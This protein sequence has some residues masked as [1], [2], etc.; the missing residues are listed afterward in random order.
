M[1]AQGGAGAGP[2]P[3]LP[4]RGAA[5]DHPLRGLRHRREHRVRVG[6][7]QLRHGR[8]RGEALRL[9]WQP[10]RQPLP[11]RGRLLVVCDARSDGSAGSGKT[12]S[13]SWQ[14]RPDCRSRCATSRPHVQVEQDRAPAVLPHHPHLAGSAADDGKTPWPV[15][16]TTTYQGLKAPPSSTR[17]YPGKIKISDQQMKY[18]EERI[19]ARRRPR[20]MELRGPARSPPRPD[21][22]PDPTRGQTR[23]SHRLAALAAPDPGPAEAVA[24]PGRRPRA[25][26]HL[27]ARPPQASGGTPK[28]PSRP[29]S[30][31]PPATSAPHALPAARR[32]RRPRD[33]HQPPPPRHPAPQNTHHPAPRHASPPSQLRTRAPNHLPPDTAPAKPAQRTTKKNRRMRMFS[34]VIMKSPRA[35]PPQSLTHLGVGAS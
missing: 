30:P 28:L 31:P 21:P 34:F 19:L 23:L 35:E 20:R 4:R 10:G 29:S 33:H 16:A 17:P 5:E 1:A 25:A 18:L 11:R 9:W 6:G 15:A 3:R 8:V 22:E 2:R 12:S 7:H 27:A 13:P 14:R 32:A 24:C 26:L